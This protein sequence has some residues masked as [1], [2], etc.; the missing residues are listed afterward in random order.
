MNVNRLLTLGGLLAASTS[1]LAHGGH[2]MVPANSLLHL[3][4]HDWPLLL[5]TLTL[6][7]LGVLLT[8]TK[9]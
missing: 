9:R 5:G 1:A 8:Q 2:A 7:T 4:A 6:A 3:L